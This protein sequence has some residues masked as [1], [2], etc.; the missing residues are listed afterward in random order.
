MQ[1]IRRIM[2][3]EQEIYK[4]QYYESTE[5]VLEVISM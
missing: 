5:K 2:S 1:N 4:E 3:E